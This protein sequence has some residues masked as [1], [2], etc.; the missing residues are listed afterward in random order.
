M[1]STADWTAMAADLAAVRG[2]NAVSIT[3]RRGATTVAAQSVRIARITSRGAS[4]G[5]N[6]TEEYRARV[7]I[8]GS[9]SFDVQ[10]EDRFTYDSILYRVVMV[11]P[12]Q[13]AAVV[14]EAEMVE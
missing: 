13:R 11:R 12:N 4:V 9:T 2:D 10:V 3:L 6:R 8:L 5:G 14:A 7:V 1:L